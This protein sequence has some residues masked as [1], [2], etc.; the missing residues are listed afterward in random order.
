MSNRRTNHRANLASEEPMSFA[1]PEGQVALCS[2]ARV[3]TLSPT[4]RVQGP[5]RS[6]DEA[7]DGPSSSQLL[8]TISAPRLPQRGRLDEGTKQNPMDFT[9]EQDVEDATTT[10]ELVQGLDNAIALAEAN[11]EENAYLS[12]YLS[13]EPEDPG[14]AH[15]SEAKDA[16]QVA[17]PGVEPGAAE[18]TNEGTASTTSTSPQGTPRSG[19]R[20]ATTEEPPSPSYSPTAPTHSPSSPS[21]SP[22]HSA[23][24]EEDE[25]ES[26]AAPGVE[27]SAANMKVCDYFMQNGEPTPLG[28][29]DVISALRDATD[30][31]DVR[32]VLTS[33][34]GVIEYKVVGL[35]PYPEDMYS[36]YEV[37]PASPTTPPTVTFKLRAMSKTGP[38]LNERN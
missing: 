33:N 4:E 9:K 7:S 30:A 8:T 6:S 27:P 34:I 14:P 17:A 25:D 28:L 12:L 15:C 5:T 22:T 29:R 1:P 13:E 38:H 21:Y 20:E 37:L 32:L 35:L 11:A 23:G 19:P 36:D 31:D 3:R 18:T 2:V 16:A 10:R 24:E 26:E